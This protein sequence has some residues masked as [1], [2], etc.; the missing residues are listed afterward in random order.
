MAESAVL[1]DL[2][3]IIGGPAVMKLLA[4]RGGL[5]VYI[6]KAA[7]LTEDHWLVKTIGS[8]AAF[9]MAKH[10]ETDGIHLPLG[11][12]KGLRLSTHKKVIEMALAGA[13]TSA[14]ACEIGVSVST[15][16][17]IKRKYLN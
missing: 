8:E 13:G 1:K 14:I 11:Q 3:E 2:K 5:Q 6:P 12:E 9:K 17:R 7:S 15:V 4:A 16:R 10:Y